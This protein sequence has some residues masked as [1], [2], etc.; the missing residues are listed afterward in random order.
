VKPDTLWLFGR[1]VTDYLKYP[2]SN[3]IFLRHVNPGGGV[4]QDGHNQGHPK[5]QAMIACL[6]LPSTLLRSNFP[7]C[8]QDNQCSCGKYQNKKAMTHF[9]EIHTEWKTGKPNQNQPKQQG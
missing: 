7:P 6:A 9:S 5:I 8:G 3:F 4:G 1:S 2:V